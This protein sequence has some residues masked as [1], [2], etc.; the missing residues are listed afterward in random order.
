MFGLPKVIAGDYNDVVPDYR[1]GG[2]SIKGLNSWKGKEKLYKNKEEILSCSVV[3]ENNKASILGKAGWGTVGAVAL[4]P[5][6][7]LAGVLA[8]G[9]KKEIA[10]AIEFNDGSKVMI[11]GSKKYIDPILKFS[12]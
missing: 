8:G 6:G 10:L 2:N 3:S 12:W 9:N 11:S 5:I 7:L 4:G 1:F